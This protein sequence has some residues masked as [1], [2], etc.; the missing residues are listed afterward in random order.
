[1]SEYS[2]IKTVLT[3]NVDAVTGEIINET[4]EDSV[5]TLKIKSSQ[6]EEFWLIYASCINLFLGLEGKFK[7]SNIAKDILFWIL[8][9]YPGVYNKIAI[10]KDLKED[11]AK[12]LGYSLG[13]ICNNINSLV[14]TELLLKE[15]RSLFRVNPKYVWRGY[16][17]DRKMLL[18]FNVEYDAE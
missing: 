17:K 5:T 15:G 4:L 18:N 2:R 9:K 11:I 7:P 6:P 12:D 10:T 16:A 8:A 3:R 13:A 1:M 14:K